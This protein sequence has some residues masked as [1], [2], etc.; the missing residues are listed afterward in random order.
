M[1]KKGFIL[2]FITAISLSACS[3]LPGTVGIKKLTIESANQS[4]AQTPGQIE[5]IV[6]LSEPLLND[7]QILLAQLDIVTGE[8][9]APKFTQFTKIDDFKYKAMLPTD[10]LGTLR[11]RYV[12]VGKEQVNE[13]FIDGTSG[14]RILELGNV[15]S[16]TDYIAGW[17]NSNP[18][19]SGGTLAGK[20]F[21]SETDAPLNGAVVQIQGLTVET[22]IFGRY[23]L[24]NLP[25][26]TF[27]VH[28]SS[29]DDQF[30]PFQQLAAVEDG[31]VTVA[32]IWLKERDFKQFNFILDVP[33]DLITNNQ[34]YLLGDVYQLGQR[35]LPGGIEYIDQQAVI[36]MEKIS[37]TRYQAVV[38]LGVGQA[39]EYK[40]TTGD[41]FWGAERNKDG[42]N[43]LRQ[44][45]VEPNGDSVLDQVVNWG[46]SNNRIEVILAANYPKE[47]P[48]T[49]NLNAFEWSNPI[50]LNQTERDS[51][52]IEL[53]RPN[54]L[55]SDASI[56]ICLGFET[57]PPCAIFS[58]GANT[59]KINFLESKTTQL[60]ISGWDKELGEIY[61]SDFDISSPNVDDFEAGFSYSSDR[62]L[63]S[64]F[65]FQGLVKIDVPKGTSFIIECIE[66]FEL[67][68][69]SFIRK[70]GNFPNGSPETIMLINNA[71]TAGMDPWLYLN[72]EE[73]T[74]LSDMAYSGDDPQVIT[75]A[76]RMVN[77]Q[78]MILAQTA[79]LTGVDT[80]II[81]GSGLASLVPG[82][83]AENFANEK[84]R[85]EILEIL[86]Q[87]LK[88]FRSHYS[89]KIYYSLNYN[90]TGLHHL[91]NSEPTFDGYLID[92]TTGLSDQEI[93]NVEELASN[94]H[95]MLEYDII[96]TIPFGKRIIIRANT[97]ST[98]GVLLGCSNNETTNCVEYENG[99]SSIQTV[100]Q[101][102]I[103]K[104]FITA[105]SG[106]TDVEG[107]ISGGF[108]P[109]SLAIDQTSNIY[110]KPAFADFIAWLK[111]IYED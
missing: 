88:N 111:V 16:V 11:Y 52:Y 55:V 108:D 74:G 44:F 34:I 66:R 97:P 49:I 43:L 24:V 84:Y 53:P 1:I 30:E 65:P 57:D 87:S 39:I 54:D 32:D 76:L 68:G 7:E 58:D 2:L 69:N 23:E 51:Y 101:Q 107:F 56:K 48:I 103:Y 21:S 5:F 25:A 104:A 82:I 38:E 20:V 26:G 70:S 75:S 35:L 79:N 80:I 61:S 98:A 64:I 96:P 40:Y 102:V 110:G 10:H 36:K 45:I 62:E 46:G 86:E 93:A 72:I 3:N 83:N 85:T 89:G 31:K 33:P 106:R 50:S 29:P 13:Q 27:F 63:S 19:L 92:W 77:E 73:I 42:S 41:G 91:P 4:R 9:I 60:I 90:N 37:A 99:N 109:S 81:G 78:F 17:S 95:L 22:D 28:F 12:K 71:K 105:I 8:M 18:T 59:V 47:I 94:I 6:D 67:K 100:T 15:W 14:Y